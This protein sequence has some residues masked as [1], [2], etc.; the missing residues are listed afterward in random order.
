ML[1]PAVCLLWFMGAAMHN[2]RLAARQKLVDVYRVQLAVS[3][4]RLQEYW[5]KTT[6]EL[7]KFAATSFGPT[8][9]AKCIQS[10]LVDG[11]VIFDELGH[12][13]YPNSP[14]AMKS[15][16]GELEA[17]WQEASRLE[18]LRKYPDAAKRYD[19]LARAGT[20]NINA[21][22]RAFQSEI[23]CRV[24]AG[25]NEAVIELVSDLFGSEQFRQAVDLQGR[26][27]AA[28]AELL[29]LELITNRT[30]PIFQSLARRLAAR[31]MDYENPVLAAP[32]RRFLMAEVQRLSPQ[33]IEFPMLVAEQL[34]AEVS[35]N[36]PNPAQDSALQRSGVPGLWQF[37]TPNNRML[38]LIQSDKLLAA[39]R[40]A[41]APD[42]SLGG[43]QVTL[44]P[45]ESDPAGAF[46]T[47]PAGDQLPGW[48]LALSVKDREFLEATAGRQAAIYLWTAIFVMAGMSVLTLVT[49]RLLRRQMAL[50]RLK[51]DLA[52]TVSHELKTPLAS[53][54]V[55]V[56]TLLDSEKF[57]EQQTREYLDLIAQENERLSRLIQNFLTFSRMERRKHSFHFSVLPARQLV[58]GAVAL[59]RR[60]FDSPGCRL[61]IQIEDDL[62][63]VMADP[64]ALAGALINLVENA[65]KYSE[66]IKHI[67]LRARAENGNVVFSVS[68]NGI[69]IASAERRRIFQPFYRVDERL[70]RKGGGCGLGLSIVQF[71]VTAHHGS[72]S[73][74]SDPGCGSTFSISLPVVSDAKTIPKEAIA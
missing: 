15:D 26:L 34:T 72:V 29:A 32:Q 57:D 16:F 18:Y 51:N 45:P 31:L 9:F 27:I 20:T 28:N 44:A 61:D 24:Q 40:S 12:I 56:E 70:S 11:A 73:V 42:H 59:A 64:D 25:Q 23:R 35:E 60:R 43:V 14:S 66:E 69:G 3:Q 38:A 68:D 30:S 39:A 55:L 13:S 19:A 1:V 65:Y 37:T 7:D 52:A 6:D 5:K 22:A 74:E 33:K 48:R 67:V 41:A 4:T 53:M 2:E 50:A 63:A 71:I 8:A 62:P 54:R 49:L 36:H 58:E 46:V 10:G 17:E 47:L 21:A